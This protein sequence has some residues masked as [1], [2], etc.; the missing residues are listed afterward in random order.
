VDGEVRERVGSALPWGTWA[1]NLSGS[2]ALG[3]VAGLGVRLPAFAPWT[4]VLGTG[5]LGGFTTFSTA[6]IETVR[7][8]QGRRLAAAGL[9]L[10]AMLAAGIALAGTGYWVAA[11]A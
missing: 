9:N 3:L 11:R 4:L 6:M 5:F 1:I 2:L 8:A 10:F 7:L